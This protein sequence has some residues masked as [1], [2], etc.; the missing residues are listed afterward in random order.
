MKL[1]SKT[2]LVQA[3]IDHKLVEA[4][5]VLCERQLRTRSDIIRQ[6]ILKELEA[7]GLCPV[8]HRAA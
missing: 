2:E 3:K 8:R 6:G 4:G 5:D 7:N 1:K